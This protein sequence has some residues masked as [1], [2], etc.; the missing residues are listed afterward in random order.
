M[1]DDTQLLYLEPD[2]EITTVVRRLREADA[3]R[4][5][6]VVSGRTKATTSAVALRLLAQEA[7][8]QGR[9]IVLVADAAAR[10]MAA[11]AG[12]AAFASVAEANAEGAVPVESPPAPRAPIH[13]VRGEPRPAAPDLPDDA[14]PVAAPMSTPRGLEETQAVPVQQPARYPVPRQPAPRAASSR[15]RTPARAARAAGW[16]LPAIG[17]LLLVGVGAALAT[18][19]PAANVVIRPQATAVGPVTY[20]V[21]PDVHAGAGDPLTATKQGEATGHRTKRTAAKGVVTFVNY[22]GQDVF[23]PSGT[24]VS[25]GRE[26]VFRITDPV[27]VPQGTI[28][29]GPGAANA[30][31]EAVER[32]TDGNV[33]AGAIDT[34]EDKDLDRALRGGGGNRTRVVANQE[35][36]TGG[37]EQELQVVRKSDIRAV[38]DAIRADLQQQL[39]TLREESGEDRIYAAD[40]APKPQIDIPKDLE[41]HASADPYTFELTGTLQDDQPYVLRDEVVAQAAERVT[42]DQNAVPAGRTIQAESIQVEIGDVALAGGRIDVQ[43]QVNAQAV[44]QYEE[45]AIAGQIAGL[46]ADDAESQLDSIG[47][48]TVTLWP[49]WVDRV[50]RLDWRVTVDVRPVEPATE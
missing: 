36:T 4:V 27:T 42:Q 45:S 40:G 46:S 21:R 47:R 7:A 22:S 16:V 28:F 50:P 34:L 49:F 25:A 29:G 6:L 2:D 8:D 23:V 43:A 30:P 17:L 1:P 12:I 15:P 10:A 13:V 32:G 18:V 41:G 14:L 5:V 44:P 26:I 9:E 19:L 37:D 38:T 48:T 35:P 3:P 20:T 11:E 39:A 33:D 24:L 31:I